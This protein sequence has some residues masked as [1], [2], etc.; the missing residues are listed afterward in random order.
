MNTKKIKINPWDKLTWFS[1]KLINFHK[2]YGIDLDAK[3]LL[4]VASAIRLVFDILKSEENEKTKNE[5]LAQTIRNIFLYNKEKDTAEYQ[6]L[7]SLCDDLDQKVESIGD[8]GVFIY[9]CEKIVAPINAAINQISSDD[10]FFDESIAKTLLDRQGVKGLANLINILD[11]IGSKGCMSVEQEQIIKSSGR[12]KTELMKRLNEADADIVLTAFCQEFERRVGQK[13]KGR[14][15]RSVEG[16]TS[17]IMNYF[18]IKTTHAPEHFTTGLEID[19]WIKTKDRWIIGIS[20]KRTLRE[21]WKQAYTTDLDLLNRHKIREL[22][23]VI[24]YDKDLSDEK[25]TEIGSHKAVL[26][27][28]DDSDRLKRAGE[29]PGMKDYVR[30]MTHF[31]DDLRKLVD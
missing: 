27:L 2:H 31:I 18:G 30:P 20:C 1:L 5:I 24:T 15:G 17:L 21:R 14:A 26:Y 10:T 7:N 25:I 8:Y 16:T 22:W 4:C 11:G 28:P 19:K 6:A 23:H 9:V 29:H 13:R 12:L 3:T